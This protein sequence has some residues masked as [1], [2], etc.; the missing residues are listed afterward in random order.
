MA[1]I[2]DAKFC[3][4]KIADIHVSKIPQGTMVMINGSKL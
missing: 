4:T 3:Q 2:Y 1:I